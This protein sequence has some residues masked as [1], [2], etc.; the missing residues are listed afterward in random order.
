MEI[1]R[2]CSKK[3]DHAIVKIGY[4]KQQEWTIFVLIWCE[5]GINWDLVSGM[6]NGKS[7]EPLT[8]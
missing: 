1:I 5:S 2:T 6:E 8:L 3:N 4:T 7:C